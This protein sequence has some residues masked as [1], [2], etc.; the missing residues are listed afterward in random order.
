[1]KQLRTMMSVGVGVLA[2]IAFVVGCPDDSD[3]TGGASTASA[4]SGEPAEECPQFQVRLMSVDAVDDNRN[5]HPGWEPFGYSQ[6][7]VALRRCIL[8]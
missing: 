2:G 7:V 3:G 1:M 8:I 5:V 6:G 4:D